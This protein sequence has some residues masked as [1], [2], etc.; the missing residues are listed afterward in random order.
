MR[1]NSDTLYGYIDD[2]KLGRLTLGQ[3]SP[4]TDDITLLNLGSEM[5]N[6]ALHYNNRFGV[7]LNLG[8]GYKQ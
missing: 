4:A 2:R 6:A 8:S 7:W 3:Q 5:N 1:S